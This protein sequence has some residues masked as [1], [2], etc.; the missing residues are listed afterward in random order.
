MANRDY[1][2]EMAKIWATPEKELQRN[3][4]LVFDGGNLTIRQN[5]PQA[6][7]GVF[8]INEDQVELIAEKAEWE[9]P[10]SELKAL[11]DF[12]NKAFPQ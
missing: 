12:L 7:W 8:A 9:I 10:P 6:G 5:G 3:S 2:A 1:P 11:R 4:V